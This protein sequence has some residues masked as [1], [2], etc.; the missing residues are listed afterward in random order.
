MTHADFLA[1]EIDDP[2]VV[3]TYS[4]VVRR[5]LTPA[6]TDVYEAVKALNTGD[7]VDVESFLYWYEGPQPHINAISSAA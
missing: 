3:E 5:Y 2:V 1:A 7:T 6:W 4:F